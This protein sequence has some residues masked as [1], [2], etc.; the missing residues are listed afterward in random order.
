[1][2]KSRLVQWSQSLESHQYCSHSSHAEKGLQK[3]ELIYI[4]IRAASE[5]ALKLKVCMIKSLSP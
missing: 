4:I 3:K 5:H 2:Q 1:V